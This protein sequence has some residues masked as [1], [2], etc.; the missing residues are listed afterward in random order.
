MEFN[1]EVKYAILRRLRYQS[2]S[3]TSSQS[4]LYPSF[5]SFDTTGTSEVSLGWTLTHSMLYQDTASTRPANT[6]QSEAQRHL[7]KADDRTTSQM[8]N[9]H[10]Q[11][12]QLEA[13]NLAIVPRAAIA[14]PVSQTTLGEKAM[15]SCTMISRNSLTCRRKTPIMASVKRLMNKSLTKVCTLWHISTLSLN[16]FDAGISC[17]FHDI[18]SHF[19]V[20][21]II[22]CLYFITTLLSSL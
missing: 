6:E 19:Y 10:Q 9:H 3:P 14:R 2:T 16:V 5:V 11:S 22:S 21:Q 18:L 15:L 4:V 7:G 1:N 20:K 17:S 12:L 13:Q 8:V